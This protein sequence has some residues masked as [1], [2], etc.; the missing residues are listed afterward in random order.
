MRATP[1]ASH[2]VAIPRSL[3]VLG[4]YIA[5]RITEYLKLEWTH[6]DH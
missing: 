5:P 2:A 3:N 4:D 6:K 1:G